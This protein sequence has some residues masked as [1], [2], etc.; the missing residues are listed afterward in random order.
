MKL[1]IHFIKKR[2]I[3]KNDILYPITKEERD[4]FRIEFKLQESKKEWR[5]LD[6]EPDVVGKAL[7]Y[8]EEQAS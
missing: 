4:L 8:F 2:C 3:S 6:K 7:I 1:R 5:D